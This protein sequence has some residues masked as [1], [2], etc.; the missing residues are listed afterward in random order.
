V[1]AFY[2]NGDNFVIAQREFRIRAVPSA[3]AIK[4]WVR[5][6][7]ATGPTLKK[8]GCSVN[9]V[10]TPEN[11]AVVREAIERSPYCSARRHSLSLGLSEASVRW[12][13]HKDLHFCPYKIQFTHALHERDYVNRVNFCQTFLL[14]INQNQELVNNLL[15]GDEAHFHLFGFV[16]KQNFRYW[17]ATNPIE[18]HERPLHRSKATVW[19][20]ISSFGII[21]AYFFEDERERAVTVTGFRYVHMLE[22]FLG[23]ELA[24]H[25]ATEETFFQQDEA[26]C[27]TAR[28]SMAAVKNLFPNRVISRYGDITWPATSPD[29]LACDFFLW[30]YLKSQVFKA[31]APHTVH[32]LKH[33]IQQEVKRIPVEMLQR[34]MGDIRKRHTEC[35]ER[36]GGHLNDVIFGK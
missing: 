11:I 36:N 10:R 7:E 4:T 6:F 27:H 1:K 31:P 35:L 28:D 21:G 16:N 19:C 25:L 14:L 3:H 12:I 34:V 9:T 26:T 13:L 15:M 24:L 32:E 20:A 29:L 8:K 5:N 33:R 30:G 18:F 23:P 22:K 17:S 2:K